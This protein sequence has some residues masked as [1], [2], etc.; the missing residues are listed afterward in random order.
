LK[1]G[2]WIKWACHYTNPESR[3]VAQGQQTTDEMC[4]FV[5]VYWPR[6]PEMDWCMPAATPD[7][8]NPPRPYSSARLLADGK[9]NASE[10]VDCWTKSPQIVGGGG[11][12][13]S[14]DRYATQSCFT[15]SCAKVAGQVNDIGSGKIDPTTLTCD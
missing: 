14:A 6:T 4:M 2:Q 7:A 12:A 8:T 13:S 10:F 15:Q 1:T 5:G 11:P 3:N 9:M